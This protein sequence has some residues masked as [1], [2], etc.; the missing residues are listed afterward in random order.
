M[1]KAW[2]VKAIL[3]YIFIVTHLPRKKVFYVYVCL[4]VQSLII[5]LPYTWRNI[6]NFF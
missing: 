3:K 1:E 5:H 4:F 6:I 2:K